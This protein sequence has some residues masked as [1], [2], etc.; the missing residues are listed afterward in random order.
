MDVGDP[1]KTFKNDRDPRD[2]ANPGTGEASEVIGKEVA[3]SPPFN[4]D[5]EDKEGNQTYAS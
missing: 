1:E 4:G 3:E 2:D 5:N